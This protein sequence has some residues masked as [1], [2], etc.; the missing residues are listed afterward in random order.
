M[1]TACATRLPA[2]KAVST[3]PSLS[4]SLPPPVSSAATAGPAAGTTTAPGASTRAGRPTG[5]APSVPAAARLPTSADL[6]AALLSTA[7]LAGFSRDTT[8]EDPGGSTANCPA[9]DD[10]FSGGAS[11]TAEA[12]FKKADT[13]P[14]V[15][16]R[17]RQLSVD[18]AARA[19]SAIAG[20]PRACAAFTGTTPA[21][22]TVRFTVNALAVP[23][24]G[25]GAAGLRIT[26]RPEAVSVVVYENVVVV[27]RGG[28]IILIT[29]VDLTSID[30]ALTSSCASKAYQKT[31]LVW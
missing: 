1:L 2:P 25:D 14:F 27:R 21:L 15:R 23:Q 10:D 4:D 8:N 12:L 6:R 20:L 13:G 16:E 3:T 30:N 17:L 18:A 9:L 31:K 26:M 19:V 29:H 5:K 7:D 24:F 28:T 22:G 11:G